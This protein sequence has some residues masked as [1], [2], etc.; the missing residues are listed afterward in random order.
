MALRLVALAALVVV[1]G[2]AWGV[3]I[4][5]R[6]YDYDEVL[7][8]HE[9][10]L[11]SQGL[12]PYQDFFEVHPP[13]FALLTPIMS[14][15]A[16]PFHALVALRVTSVAGNLAFLAALMAIAASSIPSGRLWAVLGV[17]VVA[18]HQAVL[19][20]L[21]EFRIDGWAFAM[22]AWGLYRFRRARSPWRF[23]EMGFVT[24]LASLLFSMKFAM[25]PPLV[26]VIKGVMDRE[27][28]RRFLRNAAAYGLGL[29]LA[30]FGVFLAI[31]G[32]GP[33]RTYSIGLRFQ[34]AY[35]TIYKSLAGFGLLR[36][37]G[38]WRTLAVLTGAG[39]IAWA[40][41]R[42]A[43]RALPEPYQI[44]MAVWLAIMAFIVPLPYKQYYA[45]WFLFATCFIA[46]LG[47]SLDRLPGWLGTAAFV[48]ACG[49]S[50]FAVSAEARNWYRTDSAGYDRLMIGFLNDI[51]RPGDRVVGAPPAHPIDRR[52]A[53]YL[54]LS[55][56][57]PAG[58]ADV[59][60]DG[61]PAIRDRVS[62]RRYREELEAFPPAFIVLRNEGQGM[63]Y[64][65][66]QIKVLRD[67]LGERSYRVRKVGA[68][69]IAIRPDR[70]PGMPPG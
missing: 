51:S 36:E 17:A 56:L 40:A 57:N 32:P 47:P 63:P 7:R 3:A 6:G 42:V 22:M 66:R 41:D 1:G 29:G 21:A 45:P 48:A 23:A 49:V 4:L 69:W 20:F 18:F 5:Y 70:L 58:D 50:A 68:H 65:A 39:L 26:V 34:S 54:A 28:P 55:T 31:G 12:R 13:Y 14:R 62:A 2:G 11:V 27:S 16:D 43:R 9:V 53:F 24:G 30:A 44:A 60:L 38:V 33:L 61:F 67:F 37:L 59:I 46:F 52:D 8:A 19:V 25:L 10:W 15:F 64:S 35:G